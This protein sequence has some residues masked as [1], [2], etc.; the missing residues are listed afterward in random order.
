VL[1]DSTKR[2]G[3]EDGDQPPVQGHVTGLRGG[4]VACACVGVSAWAAA[5]ALADGT[6]SNYPG[7][8]LHVTTA[9]PP[10][11][12]FSM[13]IVATGT[14]A[15]QY[16]PADGSPLT[17]PYELYLFQ[18]DPTV[19]PPCSTSEDDEQVLSTGGHGVT[20]ISRP[21][22]SEGA[23]GP[24]TIEVPAS[25][26]GTISP[27]YSGPL[28]ICAYTTYGGP[29]DT[30]AW[31]STT[32]TVT[33][34]PA[35]GV[36]GNTGGGESGTGGG[37]SHRPPAVIV[38]PTVTRSGQRLLCTSGSWSG[39]PRSYRYRWLVLHRPGVVLHRPGVAGRARELAVTAAVRGRKVECSVT[40][41]NRGGSTTATSRPIRVS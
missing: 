18:V 2:E 35:V 4:V 29:F 6:S 24:F 40:A 20:A 23:S 22:L 10:S 14:N 1:G 37:A 12:Q 19:G 25:V 39:R 9:A 15:Q 36:G 21:N 3:R 16:S 17:G 28:L 5:P 26:P 27:D 32:V 11:S 30:A 7:S 13:T 33:P 38:R 41:I 31:A 8:V 34:A